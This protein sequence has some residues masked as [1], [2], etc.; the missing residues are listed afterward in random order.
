M[1]KG[2]LLHVHLDATVDVAFLLQLALQ[3]PALHIRTTTPLT[4]DNITHHLPEFRP[5][6]VS[7][8]GESADIAS[9]TYAPGAWVPLNDARNAFSLGPQMFD[10][11]ILGALTINP[12]EAYN[13]HNTVTKVGPRILC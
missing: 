1:P 13:T 7:E 4:P 9:S 10:K 2:G 11:W 8:Y 6:P 5:L 12:M 3:Q